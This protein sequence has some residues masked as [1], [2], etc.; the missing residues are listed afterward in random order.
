MLARSSSKPPC[1]KSKVVVVVVA[2]NKAQ[3]R[4]DF[5]PVARIVPQ[6]VATQYLESRL[7]HINRLHA[8]YGS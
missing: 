3:V 6:A 2:M 8:S 1:A 4:I 7:V 5:L